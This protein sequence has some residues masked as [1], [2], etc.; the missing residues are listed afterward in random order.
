M[1]IVIMLHGVG[2]YAIR[3]MRKDLACSSLVDGSPCS[4][5]KFFGFERKHM[6]L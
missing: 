3:Y 5:V 2:F 6:Q 4:S 1:L